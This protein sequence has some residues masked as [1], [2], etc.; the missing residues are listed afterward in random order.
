MKDQSSETGW[1]RAL[2]CGAIG[3]G[4][5]ALMMLIAAAGWLAHG[6][7]IADDC[8]ALSGFQA[9]GSAYLCGPRTGEHAPATGGAEMGAED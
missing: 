4:L 3:F 2:A 5:A 8:R 9:G 6:I 1:A 7:D